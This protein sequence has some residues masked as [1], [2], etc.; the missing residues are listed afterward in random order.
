MSADISRTRLPR[1]TKRCERIG[2]QKRAPSC[3]IIVQFLRG[4]IFVTGDPFHSDFVWRCFALGVFILANYPEQG[5]NCAHSSAWYS[6]SVVVVPTN[7]SM[8]FE[9]WMTFTTCPV[10]YRSGLPTIILPDWIGRSRSVNGTT[11]MTSPRPC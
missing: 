7:D 3:H 2:V 9:L 4:Q 10:L 6:E 1:H 11:C 8:W 5:F